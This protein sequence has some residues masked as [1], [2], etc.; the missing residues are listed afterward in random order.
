[1][2]DRRGTGDDRGAVIMKHA[3]LVVEWP[4]VAIIVLN[5]NGWQDTIECLESL[6][7]ITYPNYEV[8][9]VDNGSKDESIQEIRE[10]CEGNIQVKSKF[11]EYNSRNKPITII[12]YTR[13]HAEDEMEGTKIDD[14]SSNK[15]LIL[16]KNEKNYGFAEGNNIGFRYAINNDARYLL[17]LNNDT[18]VANDFLEYMVEVFE[19]DDRIGIIGPTIFYYDEPN[20]ISS[21]GLKINWWTA[22][23]K[24]IKD[25]SSEIVN[26][27]CVSGCAMIISN[28]LL[29]EISLFDIRFPFGSEDY[30]FCTRAV[31]NGYK[32]IYVPNSKIWH[33]IARSRKMLM[34]NTSERLALFG[35]KENSILKDRALKNRLIF[36]KMYSPTMMHYLSEFIFLWIRHFLFLLLYPLIWFGIRLRLKL[37][38]TIGLRRSLIK[39]K[40]ILKNIIEEFKLRK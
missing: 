5:W 34:M 24:Q 12:E 13:I 18:V 10:Y 36:Y 32:V 15:K 22:R 3:K 33:K 26:V 23:I 21:R 4:K 40:S 11:F 8:I 30:E 7:Q 20:W 29:N 37:G 2:G 14:I 38:L 1:M 16:I 25:T 35:N 9:V 19:I 27:D 17:A 39:G 28:K 6:Y 31:R